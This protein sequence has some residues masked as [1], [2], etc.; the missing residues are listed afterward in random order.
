MIKI[1]EII[2]IEGTDL[3]IKEFNGQRVVTFKDIDM[4]HERPEGTARKRFNDN[5]KHFIE[6]V[7]YYE[8]N[9][10]SEFRTLGLERPQ[11]GVP[12]KVVLVTESGYLMIAKS[13][14]D[15]LSWDVQRS[16]VD[17]YFRFKEQSVQVNELSP[18]LQMFKQIFDTVAKQEIRQ[19]AL[20]IKVEDT[21]QR[22]DNI[23]GLIVLNPKN[24]RTE[25]EKIIMM[26]AEA[27]G[28]TQYIAVTRKEIYNAMDQRLGK[29]LFDRLKRRRKRM[30]TNGA[31]ETAIKRMS[32]LDIIETSNDSKT[33][34]EGYLFILKETAIKYGVDKVIIESKP[35]LTLVS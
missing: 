15:D 11:G 26:I 30:R 25:S 35:E 4:A 18:E 29:R 34:I 17:N 13:L 32:I 27:R 31:T 1:N 20:E 10:P 16:L 33:L 21:N 12:Q 28:G 22:I 6:G 3:K 14:T 7:D 9:Q 2:N 8:L 19:K 5:K 24:W 23:S